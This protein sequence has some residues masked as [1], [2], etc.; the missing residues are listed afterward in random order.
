[1]IVVEELERAKA[2]G[3]QDLR[4]APRLRRSRPTRPT[5]PTPIRRVRAPRGRCGWH[6]TTPESPRRTSATSNAHGTSTPTGDSAE[7]RVLKLVARRGA[8]LPNTRLVDEG[9]DRALPR[10]CRR[11]G[12]DLHD[13][14]RRARCAAA[15]DQLRS[16]RSRVRPRLHPE[17]RTGAP[18]RD[19]GLEL[20]RVR[21]AQRVPRLPALVSEAPC[22]DAP[23]VRARAGAR[24]T[25]CR[26]R[27]RA[28]PRS[29]RGVPTT[30]NPTASCSARLGPFS[31]K[32]LAWIVQTPL[33]SAAPTS[34][35]I[36]ARP[37]P[38]PRAL[39]A[40]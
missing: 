40:T 19:R 26:A 13:P 1:M 7:T 11:S 38:R 3:A 20:V 37:T 18:G 28:A 17:H 34:A 4:R 12:G 9:R 24:G 15:D 6:S 8:R 2:R 32:T 36:S 14:R 5:C 10:R 33:A 16:A 25:P 27:R 22:R 30:R 29:A 35:S 31:G 23:T 39:P 21:R